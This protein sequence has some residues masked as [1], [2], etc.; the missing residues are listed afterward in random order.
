MSEPTQRLDAALKGRYRIERRLGEGGMATVYLAEDLKHERKVA[1]KILRPELAAVI[2]ADRFIS[3]IKTTANL[4][5]PHI[6]TLFD[7]GE[8]DGFLYYVMPFIDGESLREKL[9]H[10]KQ[11][12]VD[13]AVRI[14][15]NVADA[16]DYA[17]RNDV[18]HRDIKP[19][20]ILM[21]DGR[22]VVADFGIALAISAA[23]GG[24][25]TETGLSLGTPHYM[26]PEQATADRD[27]SARSDVY[28]LGCVLYEML[29]GDPPHTGPTAQSILMRI[30]TE[31][32][33]PVEEV[34]A[35]V[36]P[37][38]AATL[39]KAL[40][41]LPADRFESAKE[42]MDA[43]GDEGFTH[44]GSRPAA[45]PP[46]TAD[47]T[48][49]AESDTPYQPPWI[50]DIRTWVAAG[51]L[52]VAAAAFGINAIRNGFT[53]G[54]FT[55]RV[56]T[57]V[58]LDLEWGT[59]TPEFDISPDGSMLVYRARGESGP[60]LFLRRSDQVEAQLLAGTEGA[61]VPVFSPDGLW[62]AFSKQNEILRISVD[63]GAP[64]L[65]VRST[66]AAA[67]PHWGSDGTLVYS[68]LDGMYRVPALGGDPELIVSGGLF[69]HRL[70]RILPD[71]EAVIY[72]QMP[73]GSEQ[74]EIH[75]IE[76]ATGTSRVLI[77]D[78]FDAHYVSS[79]H[80]VYGRFDQALLAV[81]FDLATHQ[82]MGAPVV[83]LDSVAIEREAGAAAFRVSETGT[84]V[85]AVGSDGS[86]T[87]DDDE[88]M[89]LVDH[90][91]NEEVLPISGNLDTPAFSPDGRSIAYAK[92]VQ[93]YTY[94]LILGSNP[95]LTDTGLNI[96]PT[97]SPDGE[98]IAFLSLRA[99][100][101]GGDIYVLDA[102]AGQASRP[103]WSSPGFTRPMSW[104]PDGARL[105]VVSQT[106]GGDL[107]L[108]VLTMG[109][110]TASSPYLEA[111]WD[112]EDGRI[113]PDG[114]WVAYASEETGDREIYVR[115]FPDPGEKT[116]ISEAGGR[117]AK[118]APDGGSVYY[119]SAGSLQRA[120]VRTD[121]DFEVVSRTTLF[122]TPYDGSYDVHPDGERFVFI[123]Q[124]SSPEDES[125]DSAQEE[126]D[127]ARGFIVVNWLTEMLE[128][129]G[130]S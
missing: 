1:L 127:V 124:I 63:G 13:E 84:A 45:A 33:R 130:G 42:F 100:A 46:S 125:E 50:S 113:S 8:A 54:S 98:R 76:L 14:A 61:D 2:G 58:P 52:A 121:P 49:G 74:A 120:T 94:D 3:E 108:S 109:S 103:L 9:D 65:M 80:L 115:A 70:A 7:S 37:H 129:L 43:L 23:G 86:G 38:V 104:S 68:T 17:H 31:S 27:L 79:G 53:D 26:S 97:W 55:D 72:T 83:V 78:G 15:T 19:E 21:H 16:L 110:D 59:G 82:V 126:D 24:R 66:L 106:N 57:R 48:H 20:N 5:H 69:T 99:G 90:E 35:S 101:Q 117:G 39:G 114:K 75:L 28:S 67:T 47:A 32:P 119:R 40:E 51:A 96:V 12:G 93:L 87:G 77:D 111:D 44:V 112:E 41:R 10:D 6:L 95:K 92:D 30:L 118:W 91:G 4:Q 11:L 107:D 60:Q 88:V 81:P 22:P 71:G 105:L 123:K 89:V 85:Y 102:D 64:L 128:R 56:V 18:I 29:A 34:R 73:F 116:Q 62:I 122:P 36:P 25:M